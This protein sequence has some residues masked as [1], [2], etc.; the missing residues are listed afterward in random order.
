MDFF[1]TLAEHHLGC[2]KRE[3]K[4]DLSQY[5]RLYDMLNSDDQEM[6]DLG[7]IT[8][9]QLAEINIQKGDKIYGNTF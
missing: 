2:L 8:V 1:K 6:V 9:W 4:I 3:A 5:T 7:I